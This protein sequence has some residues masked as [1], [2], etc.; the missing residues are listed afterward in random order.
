M[1]HQ[2]GILR[3]WPIDR[4][5]FQSR[6]IL[7]VELVIGDNVVKRDGLVSLLVKDQVEG[8][9]PWMERHRDGWTL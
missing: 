9:M 7:S 4:D 6:R 8:I 1:T 2:D 3:H 5:K